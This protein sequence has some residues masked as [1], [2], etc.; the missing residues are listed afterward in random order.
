ML[1]YRTK[2]DEQFW[3]GDIL[4]ENRVEK[5]VKSNPSWTRA[6][7]LCTEAKQQH[8]SISSVALLCM[9]V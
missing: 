5:L 1:T 6:D 9:R 3:G 2:L 7:I 8:A 4:G